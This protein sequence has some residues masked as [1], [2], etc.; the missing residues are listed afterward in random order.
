MT[1]SLFTHRGFT[2]LE[3]LLVLFLL[4]I[5][6]GLIMPKLWEPEDLHRTSRQLAGMIHT[7]YDQSRS[8]KILYRLYF[9]AQDGS[10]WATKLEGQN[11]QPVSSPLFGGRRTLPSNIYFQQILIGSQPRP[12]EQYMQFFPVGRVEHA[13]IHL[14]D[15][16]DVLSLIV[17]PLTGSVKI[18]NGEFVPRSWKQILSQ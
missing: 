5:V 14:A 17:H 1:P 8:S 4:T 11:E 10:Y 2:L 9:D 16:E 3:L 12:G 7:L 6:T 18:V 13:V 15:D